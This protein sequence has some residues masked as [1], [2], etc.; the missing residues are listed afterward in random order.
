MKKRLTA[1]ILAAVLSASF[2]GCSGNSA[3]VESGSSQTSPSKTEFSYEYNVEES[4]QASAGTTDPSGGIGTGSSDGADPGGTQATTNKDKTPT[5]TTK[6]NAGDTNLEG[7][8]YLSGFPIVKNK[9]DITIMAV[10]RADVGN[11]TNSQ[12]TKTISSLANINIKYQLVEEGM[13]SQRKTLALQSGN[14]P[15]VFALGSVISDSDISQYSKE[16]VFVEITEDMLKKYAPNVYALYN[17]YPETWNAVK[18]SN[19]KMYSIASYASTYPYG[20]HFLWVRKTWLDN[21]GL[22]VPKTMDEFYD[23]L[24]KFKNNDPNRN[25]QAD[26]VAYATFASSGFFFNPW[27]FDKV[28]DVDAKGRVTHM[29]TTNNMTRCLTYWNRIFKENLV[30]KNVLDNYTGNNAA[31][32]SLL[33]SGKVGAF[34]YGWP[35]EAMD[36]DLLSE[37]EPIAWPTAGDNGDF[38]SV[39]VEVENM[40]SPKGWVIT[41]ACKNVTAALRF[42][43]YLYTNDGHM[44]KMYG[45]E[46]GYYEK[47]SATKY[48]PTGKAFTK[49]SDYGPSWTLP[50]ISFLIDAE[51]EE[52]G[53]SSVQALMWQ[54]RH[55]LDSQLEKIANS[56]GQKAW[57]TSIMTEDELK[58]DKRYSTYFDSIQTR[59]VSFVRGDLSLTSD[60][61]ALKNEMNSKG[62]SEYLAYLQGY[63]DRANQ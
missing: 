52:E 2:A 59:W 50:G 13:A 32:K 6:T 55:A 58:S 23:M 15:D 40:I 34:Y 16:G 5:A 31:F 10:T 53:T 26:E 38:P 41:K 28:I 37:Y 1:F 47:Q 25:G 42:I 45:N 9:E 19:G 60:W 57:P 36:E 46:G 43:D 11:P 49:Q 62:L 7:N 20:Q 35:H 22:S 4:S 30:D 39:G 24:V 17:K 33:Q 48:V 51:F 8:T 44:L 61:T 21:L 27:G 3:P 54:K 14:L 12:F 29:Y 63:Y 56:S 18:T